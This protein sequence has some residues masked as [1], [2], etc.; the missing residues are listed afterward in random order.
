MAAEKEGR[1][2]LFLGSY[3]YGVYLKIFLGSQRFYSYYLLPPYG[4]WL[5]VLAKIV[6]YLPIPLFPTSLE[7]A[8]FASFPIV[9]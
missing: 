1:D 6:I 8:F 3:C 2:N 5:N 9:D 4:L 7:L